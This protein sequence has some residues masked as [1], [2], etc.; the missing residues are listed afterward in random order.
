MPVTERCESFKEVELGYTEA[1]AIAE[2]K[3]CLR[4]DLEREEDKDTAEEKEEAIEETVA[5]EKEEK[6]A[7][8]EK[9]E[10]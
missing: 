2:A 5:E 9:K 6:A 1:D 8:E 10:E 4:C 3:R 7:E